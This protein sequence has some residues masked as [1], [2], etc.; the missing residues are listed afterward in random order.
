MMM[1]SWTTCSL[2]AVPL[3][4]ISASSCTEVFFSS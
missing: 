2:E 4:S 1:V 3:K